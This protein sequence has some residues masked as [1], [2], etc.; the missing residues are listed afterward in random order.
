[1]DESTARAACPQFTEPEAAGIPAPLRGRLAAEK[2][3]SLADWAALS[4]RRRRSVWGIT[5]SMAKQLDALERE[6][7]P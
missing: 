7:R 3:Y 2:I 1:M 6:A 4:P 5:R